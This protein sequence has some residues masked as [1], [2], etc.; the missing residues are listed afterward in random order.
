MINAGIHSLLRWKPTMSLINQLYGKANVISILGLLPLLLIPIET[1]A[2]SGTFLTRNHNP[3]IQ[4][5]GLPAASNIEIH[6]YSGWHY[7]WNTN[8]YNVSSDS[9]K[10]SGPTDE[11]L[12][13]DGEI[14][15]TELYLNFGL[16]PNTSF[17]AHIPYIGHNSGS[18]DHGIEQW[19][20]W[21]GLSNGNRGTRDQDLLLYSYQRNGQTQV[22]LENNTSSIGDTTL[23]WRQSLASGLSNFSPLIRVGIKLP[24]GSES[25]LSGSGSWDISSDISIGQKQLFNISK[26][27]WQSSVGALWISGGGVLSSLRRD[28]VAYG[29]TTFNYLVTNNFQLRVQFDYH[30]AFYRSDILELGRNST[31][32]IVGAQYALSK[33]FNLGMYFSEDIEVDTS[34][35]FGLGFTLKYTPKKN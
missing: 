15:V 12:I 19:H 18:G 23:Q 17:T 35:D 14:Y 9:N 29:S 5:Y 3:L 27:S 33:K 31:Q 25:R 34:P 30:S 16:S 2:N 13:F 24:S 4:I 26:L 20:K 8:V 11:T 21:F 10:Q 6:K 7:D 28:L 32:L 1:K 22:Q